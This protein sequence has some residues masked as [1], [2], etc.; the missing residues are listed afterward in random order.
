MLD[1]C[2]EDC[3]IQSVIFKPI[4]ACLGILLQVESTIRHVD[5]CPVT[6]D[7]PPPPPIPVII[8][9]TGDETYN[10]ASIC[11]PDEFLCL[12]DDD[13]LPTKEDWN[14][15][16]SIPAMFPSP[17]SLS[18]ISRINS[19][20]HLDIPIKHMKCEA[21]HNVYCAHVDTAAEITVTPY[22]HLLHHYREYDESFWC[23]IRLVTALD[24]NT[25][26][27]LLGEG[28]LHIPSEDENG[29]SSIV[30]V[31][32]YYS[33]QVS[34]TLLNKNDLY[35]PLKSSITQF[36]GMRLDKYNETGNVSLQCYHKIYPR[37]NVC[38]HGIMINNKSCYTHQ[39]LV[40]DLPIN[41]PLAS[42]HTRFA[43]AYRL[44]AQFRKDVNLAVHHRVFVWQE[45]MLS[46]VRI[47]RMD[48]IQNT[49]TDDDLYLATN[50]P[51]VQWIQKATPL[52]A[53]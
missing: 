45:K 25:A 41:H 4:I 42:I 53:L 10:I 21:L 2:P 52:K 38:I 37:H 24:S 32:C 44:D 17:K 34:R 43:C 26:V 35:G 16:Q 18:H 31:R 46:K 8:N 28:L 50:L 40:P 5:V 12:E 3:N 39:H 14:I 36:R 23:P 22:K 48:L 30:I 47:Q 6:N 20:S 1:D 27:S 15:A 7:A 11:I 19:N 49:R 13:S 29:R 9:S 33:P 51:Y